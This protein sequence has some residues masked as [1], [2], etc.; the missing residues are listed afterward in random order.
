M[1]DVTLKD[2]IEIRL[3]ESY[4]YLETRFEELE[5]RMHTMQQYQDR[6]Y[7]TAKDELN[8]RLLGMNEFREQ[9]QRQATTFIT[10]EKFDTIMDSHDE[11]HSIINE[12]LLQFLSKN[13]YDTELK[14]LSD[15]I[16]SVVLWKS[17]QEGKQSRSNLIAIAATFIALA[18]TIIHILK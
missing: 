14:H 16:D 7:D 17:S 4:K 3:S 11:D 2:F 18:S 8:R 13:I 15:K 12:K 10:R 1:N 6:A 9:L 5:K